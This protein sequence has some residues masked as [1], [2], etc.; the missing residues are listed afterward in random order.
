MA[1]FIRCAHPNS[2]FTE[3]AADAH[4]SIGTLVEELNTSQDLYNSLKLVTDNPE[5]MNRYVAFYQQ[6]FC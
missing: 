3:A 6:S 5:I 4:L 1:D 2:A